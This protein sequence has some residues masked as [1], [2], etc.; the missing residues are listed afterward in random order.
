MIS[1]ALKFRGP[2]SE[3]Y[4]TS[5]ASDTIVVTEILLLLLLTTLN[6]QLFGKVFQHKVIVS[7]CCRD[8]LA[9]QLP[10]VDSSW[11]CREV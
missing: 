3:I 7:K 10:R 11:A 2:F 9:E 6:R 8:T 4:R 5:S 1:P